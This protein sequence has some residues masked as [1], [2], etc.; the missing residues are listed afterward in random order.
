[1]TLQGL[2]VLVVENDELNAQLL[3]LQLAQLGIQVLG[4]VGSVAGALEQA[5][6]TRP[7]LAILDFRLQDGETSE[8]VARQLS[9]AG[10]PF[11]L[12]TGQDREWL[13]P[14]FSSGVVLAKPYDGN[15]LRQA[16]CTA[17]ARA[18]QALE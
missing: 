4:R 11:V 5:R 8:A 10:T 9:A 14:V 17:L 12:A 2:Q 18:A 13:P 16:I 15:E 7:D 3:E 1:M 6:Q